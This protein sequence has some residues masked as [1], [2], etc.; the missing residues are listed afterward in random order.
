M[1][2]AVCGKLDTGRG[3]VY[4]WRIGNR[5]P[6]YPL[7]LRDCPRGRATPAGAAA[8]EAAMTADTRGMPCLRLIE[9]S[10]APVRPEIFPA[11]QDDPEKLARLQGATNPANAFV[12]RAGGRPVLIDSGWGT[13]GPRKG[14][15]LAVLRASG[16]DP[17]DIG[18]ILLTHMHIDHISGLI[19]GGEAVFPN[20]TLFVS[21][22]EF[23]YWVEEGLDK[24]PQSVALARTVAGIYKG[25]IRT[26]TFGETLA[27]GIVA[28]AAV[29]HT[30]GHTAFAITEGGGRCILMGDVMH[31]AELQ[32][33]YPD[34][35][36]SF[37]VDPV[38][39]A[40]TR[41]AILEQA[42]SGGLLLAGAHIT[43]LGTVG[44]GPGTGFTFTPAG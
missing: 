22:P 23:A 3:P 12:V 30:P 35:S 7:C 42:C 29:G 14:K 38:Q 32:F 8:K 24:N 21:R 13:E 25:R 27:P 5:F 16:I 43:G 6:E 19:A 10:R 1:P 17:A 36:A 26:F 39:S 44:K 34:I 11:I 4:P 40:R 33:A 18:R 9:D 37:D 31:V 28:E 20:A 15:T 41:R 2:F